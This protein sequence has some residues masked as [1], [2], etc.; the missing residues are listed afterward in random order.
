MALRRGKT[1]D[2]TTKAPA[3]KG[4]RAAAE[5][6]AKQSRTSQ[7]RQAYGLTRQ[8]DPKLPFVLLGVFLGVLVLVGLIGWLAGSPVLGVLLGLPLATLATTFVFGRRVSK[9]AFAGVEGQPGAAA[10]VLQTV[11]G[12]WKVTPAIG[13]TR[14][15]DLLHRVV[16]RPGVVLVAEGAPQRVRGLLVQEKKRLARVLPDVPVYEV[17]VGDGEGQVPLKKL[18]R[19]LFGLPRNLKPPQITAVNK[20][21]TALGQAGLPIPKGPMPAGG[22]IPR[23]KV[24]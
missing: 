8:N 2:S 12:T 11:R 21:L 18:Q 1:A 10:A 14:E 6:G 7:I 24:R 5:A 15:Q 17:L 9:A 19:H 4:A 16:G 22:R 13:F 23:G 20:R 3:G